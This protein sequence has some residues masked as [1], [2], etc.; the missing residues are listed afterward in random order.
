MDANVAQVQRIGPVVPPENASHEIGHVESERRRKVVALVNLGTQLL[1]RD[2]S[3]VMWE[4]ACQQ[5]AVSNVV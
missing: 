4:Y 3:S 2:V 1:K 5:R